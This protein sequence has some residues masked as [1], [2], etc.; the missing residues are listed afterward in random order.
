MDYRTELL[1]YIRKIIGDI[2]EVEDIVQDAL[3]VSIEKQDQLKN[4]DQYKQWLFRIGRNKAIDFLKKSK[5]IEYIDGLSDDAFLEQHL[6]QSNTISTLAANNEWAINEI[7]KMY[8]EQGKTATEIRDYLIGLN[9]D[10]DIK[11][12]PIISIEALL[13]SEFKELSQKEIADKLKLPLP[14]VKS[15]IQRAKRKVQE[16]FFKCCDFEFDSRGSI[17]DYQPNKK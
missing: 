4:Q 12:V 14:T 3:L 13:L 5:N 16:V 8:L 1:K 15:R 6:N 7:K 17:I 2:P 11:M 9:S 10:M